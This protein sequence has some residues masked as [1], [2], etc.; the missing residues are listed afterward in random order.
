MEVLGGGEEHE[1]H[2]RPLLYGEEG[3]G[4]T[5]REGTPGGANWGLDGSTFELPRNDL[6][7]LK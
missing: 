4:W 1:K 7:G 6:G 5:A 3:D 2:C